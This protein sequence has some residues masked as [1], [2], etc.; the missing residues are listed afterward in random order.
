MAEQALMHSKQK[1]PDSWRTG[2]KAKASTS[3]ALYLK[4]LKNHLYYLQHVRVLSINHVFTHSFWRHLINWNGLI[5]GHLNSFSALGG[6]NLNKIFQKFKCP[7]GMF[8]LRFDWYIMH[9]ILVR[10]LQALGVTGLDLDWII[11]YFDD[12][13]QQVF[14]NGLLSST[15][16][17]LSGVPHGTALGPILFLFYINDL[18][19]CISHSTVN[20]FADDTALYYSYN[21]TDE[22]LW[23]LN[24]DLESG[25]SRWILS[26]RCCCCR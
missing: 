25:I 19:S 4:V 16:H 3:F 9:S 14:F 5:T 22:M 6:G 18:H 8:K 26:C 21:N 15:E 13:E 10:K 2:W 17:I 12:R 20:M 1:I 23:R 11:S 7:G 24:D